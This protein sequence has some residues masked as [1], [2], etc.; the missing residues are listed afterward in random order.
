MS[1]LREPSAAAT[2]IWFITAETWPQVRT[3][4]PAAA[5]AFAEACGFEPTPGRTQILP[6]ASGAIAAILFGIEPADARTLDLLL[7]GKLAISLPTGLYRFRQCA[8]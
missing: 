6:G 7:P 5:V 8:A 3:D 2:P 1:L 4:L